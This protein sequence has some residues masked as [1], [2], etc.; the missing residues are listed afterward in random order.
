MIEAY[1]LNTYDEFKDW[2]RTSITS[3]NRYFTKH[4]V[5]LRV[6]D[7]NNYFVRKMLDTNIDHHPFIRKLTRI[8]SFLESQADI[9]IF[10]D[11]DTVV[12]K[13]EE[14]INGLIPQDKNFMHWRFVDFGDNP[15]R[16]W[17][18]TKT[19]IT[20]LF[21]SDNYNKVLNTDT[22]FA[23]YT[24]EFCQNLVDY[25]ISREL[26]I[27]SEIGLL[28]CMSINNQLRIKDEK[29]IIND[30][31]LISFFLQEND[32]YKSYTIEPPC[33]FAG[34]YPNNKI[35]S[36]TYN[37]GDPLYPQEIEFK[38]MIT[39]SMQKLCLH[40][41]IFHHLLGWRMSH[42]LVPFYVEAFKK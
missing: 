12:L 2:H 37:I 35:C 26:D 20:R 25:L 31:H 14:D 42:K 38:D 27:V 1:V 9:G 11:L 13:L 28:H 19:D 5:T 3:L 41:C 6:I 32:N 33:N 18:K 24:R 21:F 22:G 34:Q 23:I 15:D 16:P 17:L 29:Q 39:W 8:Y 4:G 7:K 36:S 40:D 30:E 10:I